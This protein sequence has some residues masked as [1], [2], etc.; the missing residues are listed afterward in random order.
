MNEKKLRDEAQL[1]R[2]AIIQAIPTGVSF[3]AIIVALAQLIVIYQR[4][5]LEDDE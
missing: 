5:A 3:A 2:Q 1:V 4:R